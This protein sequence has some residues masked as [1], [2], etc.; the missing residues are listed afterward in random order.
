[1]RY[2]MRS[3]DTDLKSWY[4]SF[5][6]KALEYEEISC[7]G[8]NIADG[9]EALIGAFFLSNNLRKTLQWL[10]DIHLVPMEQASLLEIYPDE[11]LTF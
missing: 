4:P 8:K 2:F 11:D 3:K 1:M 10:S 6:D 7:T 9:V 5:T